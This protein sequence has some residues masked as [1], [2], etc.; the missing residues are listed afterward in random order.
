VVDTIV[1]ELAV[2]RVTPAGLRLE[3]LAPGVTVEEVERATEAKLLIAD[4]T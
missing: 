2:L 4:A 3:E 1:T